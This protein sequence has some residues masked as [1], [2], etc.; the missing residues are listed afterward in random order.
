[1]A[2]YNSIILIHFSFLDFIVTAMGLVFTNLILRCYNEF[3]TYKKGMNIIPIG[4]TQNTEYN[5]CQFPHSQNVCQTCLQAR[6]WINCKFLSL[7]CAL[8]AL[9]YT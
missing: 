3:C 6:E 2:L 9:P 4:E 1:M 8:P 5:V 7:T